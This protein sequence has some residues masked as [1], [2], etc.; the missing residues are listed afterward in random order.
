[1]AGGDHVPPWMVVPSAR[2][3][4][5]SLQPPQKPVE[6]LL[7]HD[8]N[9]V[10]QRVDATHPCEDEKEVAHPVGRLS[11]VHLLLVAHHIPKTNGAESHETE[12]EGV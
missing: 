8:G 6:N 10:E 5:G 11:F 3:A 2:A 4:A 1:M 12:I 9:D 7:D